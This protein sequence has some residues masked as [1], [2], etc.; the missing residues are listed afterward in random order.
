MCSIKMLQIFMFFLFPPEMYLVLIYVLVTFFSFICFLLF[1]KWNM[2]LTWNFEQR[3]IPFNHC[4][5]QQ[6]ALTSKW[7]ESKQ[8][9]TSIEPHQTKISTQAPQKQISKRAKTKNSNSFEHKTNN[10][11]QAKTELMSCLE[12]RH[13]QTETPGQERTAESHFYSFA[14]ALLLHEM[15]TILIHL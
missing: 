12:T 5:K 11:V 6:L 3:N 9:K 7:S 8:Q 13:A 4:E 1:V 10:N 2:L 14:L 15:I